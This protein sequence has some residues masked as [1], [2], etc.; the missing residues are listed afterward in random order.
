MSLTA[1]VRRWS[2]DNPQLATSLASMV[3]LGAFA[4]AGGE[5]ALF[6]GGGVSPTG[7]TTSTS[8]P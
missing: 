7:G 1:T 2:Q 3:V 6:D 8:G 4:A 5:L